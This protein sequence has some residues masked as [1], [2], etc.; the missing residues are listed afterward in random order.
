[1]TADPRRRAAAEAA[2]EAEVRSGMRLGLGT[3]ST[4]NEALGAIGERLADGR[5]NDLVGVA[6]SEATAARCAELGIP[7]ASLDALRR[8]DL[9]VDGADEIDPQLR[10][11]KGLGGAHLREKVVA[12]AADR[13][14]VVADDSKLVSRL[15]ERAPLPVEVIPFARAACERQL[16]RAG[17]RPALRL[18]HDGHRFRTDE[19]N[20]ILDCHRDDWSDAERLADELAGIAGVVEHGLFLGLAAAAYVATPSGVRVLEAPAGAPSR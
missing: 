9:A 13:F 18:A 3:G 7:L 6:T 15:G 2:V 8:L 1:V 5:L 16:E 20:L 12:C 14:V 10:L 4:A 19:G 11:V 17:W